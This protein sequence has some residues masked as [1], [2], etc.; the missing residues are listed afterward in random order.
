MTSFSTS[1]LEKKLSDLSNTQHSVQT[2]SL[3]LIH[4]RK[5]AKAVVQAWYKELSKGTLAHVE[6][7][8]CLGPLVFLLMLSPLAGEWNFSSQIA[9][10]SL[11]FSCMLSFT[12]MHQL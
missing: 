12:L 2:L 5:H 9:E 3:W 7:V 8:F 10:I 1:T 4:H 6:T 11:S